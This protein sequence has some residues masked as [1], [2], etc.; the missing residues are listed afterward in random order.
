MRELLFKNLKSNIGQRKILS[1]TETISQDGMQITTQRRSAFHLLDRIRVQ[2]LPGSGNFKDFKCNQ[3]FK[4][5]HFYAIRRA[6]YKHGDK[7]FC[8]VNGSLYVVMGEY[9]YLIGFT[10]S[11]KVGFRKGAA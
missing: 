3:Q 11:I 10:N 9:L 6:D 5:K 2:D 1:M 8:K 4:D 7:L